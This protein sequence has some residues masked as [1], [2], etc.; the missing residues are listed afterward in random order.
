MQ[1][2]KVLAFI[3]TLLV[4]IGTS[5]VGQGAEPI[6]IGSR[7]ELFVDSHLIEAVTG[8]VQQVVQNPQPQE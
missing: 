6:D 5:M 7:L 1:I 3:V 8:D 2:A 4:T